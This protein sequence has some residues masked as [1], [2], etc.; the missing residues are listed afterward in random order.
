MSV[1]YISGAMSGK[2][3]MNFPMFNWV[4]HELRHQGWSVTNPV[5]INPDPCASWL[6]CIIADIEAMDECTAFAQLPGWE[7]SFGAWVEYIVALK[8]RKT[9][10]RVSLGEVVTLRRMSD[11]PVRVWASLAYASLFLC[12]RLMKKTVV[13]QEVVA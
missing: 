10:Y 9:I 1:I 4:A 7:E 2:P 3:D 6:P 13:T 8:Q 11:H 5:E 12:R